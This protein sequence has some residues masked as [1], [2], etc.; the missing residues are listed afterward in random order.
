MIDTERERERENREE[1]ERGKSSVITSK[2][3]KQSKRN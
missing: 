2:Q 1:R 3:T